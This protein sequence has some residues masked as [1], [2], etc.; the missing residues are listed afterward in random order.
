VPFLW[1]NNSKRGEDAKLST[2][3]EDTVWK[4]IFELFKGDAVKFFGINTK[5]TASARTELSHIPIQRKT[6]DWLWDTDEEFFLH[7]F[8]FFLYRKKDLSRFM[9]SDAILYH[10]TGKP[11]RTIVVYSAD[12][13][14]TITT[15]D[16]GAIKYNVEAFYMSTLDGDKTYD[17]IKT[18]VDANEPLTKQDLMSIV[19]LPMMKNSVDKVS[20]FEHAINLSKEISAENERVQ[21]QEMLKLLAEKFIKDVNTLQKLKELV[22]MGIINEMLAN[23]AKINATKDIAR[24]MLREGSSIEFVL[25]TTG[26]DEPT[27]LSL[28]S[29]LNAA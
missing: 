28:Q 13:K 3:V 12:V 7:F 2:Q 15:L 18:K 21:I 1:H 29:E 19:F 8:F 9:I 27:I 10:N 5:V 25:K 17:E 24:N 22:N 20:R 14:E 4:N 6:D 23:D 11:V 26:L 16:A